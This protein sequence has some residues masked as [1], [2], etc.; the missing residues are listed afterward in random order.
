MQNRAALA[1]DR[2]RPW[3]NAANILEAAVSHVLFPFATAIICAM[4]PRHFDVFELGKVKI[5]QTPETAQPKSS[6]E[7]PN[8]MS[9]CV[10][11]SRERP[12]VKIRVGLRTL[13]SRGKST[14]KP[15]HGS[16]CDCLMRVSRIGSV[17]Q[18]WLFQQIV[19]NGPGMEIGQ[20]PHATPLS[21]V[22]VSF[23]P[24]RA[25]PTEPRQ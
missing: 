9:V 15:F 23:R 3:E 6:W 5:H 8:V 24:V 25:K 12:D 14:T 16:L 4:L 1:P 13:D 20:Q 2:G 17:E 7:C 21:G 10:C 19:R 18:R 11:C 22:V